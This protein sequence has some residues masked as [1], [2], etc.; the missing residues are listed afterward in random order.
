MLYKMFAI[1]DSAANAYMPPFSLPT[2]EIA[3][4]SFSEVVNQEGHA[5]NKHPSD[6]ELFSL[7]EFNDADGS[8]TCDGPP[9]SVCRASDCVK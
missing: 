3:I 1:R 5:F 2:T 6:Y 8:V 7:G 4:R 9:H